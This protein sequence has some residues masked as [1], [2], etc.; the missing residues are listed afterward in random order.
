MQGKNGLLGYS[1][2]IVWVRKGIG[3]QKKEKMR[4]GIYPRSWVRFV[5]TE[6]NVGGILG[7]KTEKVKYPEG[8]WSKKQTSLYGERVL[9]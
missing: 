7:E 1:I 6:N 9:K 4:Y 5:Q 8:V 3:S 2:L